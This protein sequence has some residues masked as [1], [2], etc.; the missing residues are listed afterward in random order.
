MGHLAAGVAHEIR[1]PLGIIRAT[2]QIIENEHK[3]NPSIHPG[4]FSDNRRR[5]RQNEC[6]Y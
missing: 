4:V 6:G 1:N 5:M 2:M 3:D